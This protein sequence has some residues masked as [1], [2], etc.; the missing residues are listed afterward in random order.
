MAIEQVDVELQLLIDISGSVNSTE[1]QLQMDG[2]KAAFESDTVQNSIINGTNG[3]I[4]V[5]LVMWSGA[6]QQEVMIDWS[7]IDSS[8]ASNN[9]ATT[10]DSLARPFSGMTAIG[11][12]INYGYTLFENNNF[13]GL[14]QVIDVSGDGTNNNGSS[15]ST[16]RDNALAAGIDKINGIVITTNDN[17]IDEYTT[18]VVAGDNAFLLATTD[19]QDFQSAIETK[20][21]SEIS[22][23]TPKNNLI[24]NVPEPESIWLLLLPLSYLLI[25]NMR[26]NEGLL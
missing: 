16:A 8:E 21:S 24:V 4:A 23:V 13:Q 7:L 19:F 3:Q 17:V 9:F 20:I 5:Q 15:P 12:A 6:N 22:G 11:N 14:S 1:Y 2:Y 25:K 18:N 10:I 26:K